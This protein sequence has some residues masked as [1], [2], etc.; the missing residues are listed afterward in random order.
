MLIGNP[1]D[2]SDSPQNP[3]NFQAEGKFSNIQSSLNEPTEKWLPHKMVWN[4][5]DGQDSNECSS[6]NLT[7][8]PNHTFELKVIY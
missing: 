1:V 6:T 7:L 2:E 8:F 5:Y 4:V 3:E